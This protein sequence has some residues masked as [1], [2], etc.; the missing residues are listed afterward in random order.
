M[1]AGETILL[2][3]DCQATAIPSGAK[4]TL[5]VGTPVRITQFLEGS[6][7]VAVGEE[8]AWIEARDADALGIKPLPEIKAEA[9]PQDAAGGST[10][11]DLAW[12]QLRKCF[13]PELPVNIVDLGLIYDLVIT[14]HPEGGNLVEVKMT[15]TAPGCSMGGMIV[16]DARGKIL[17]IPGVTEARVELVWDPPWNQAMMTEAAKLEMGLM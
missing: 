15:L 10:T 14:P 12:K 13:D 2:L 4:T 1:P 7:M 17:G 9:A 5:A 3:R 16:E 6:H 11:E 8:F